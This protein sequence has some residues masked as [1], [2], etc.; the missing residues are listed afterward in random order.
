L[1]DPPLK[2]RASTAGF[3]PPRDIFSNDEQARLPPRTTR[4]WS[5]HP[6]RHVRDYLA[7]RCPHACRR[8]ETSL[9]AASPLDGCWRECSSHRD[10]RPR[11]PNHA[12]REHC[13]GV[14]YLLNVAKIRWADSADDKTSR[15][16]GR[17]HARTGKAPQPERQ[18]DKNFGIETELYSGTPRF[19]LQVAV[20]RRTSS[21]AREIK[22][23]ARYQVCS[24]TLCLPAR[25]DTVSAT[26]RIATR[27]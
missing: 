21:G 13:G 7:Q 8:G 5:R 24:E 11:C 12:R 22:I 18:F 4:R 19:T 25:T 17:K 10:R 27:T 3:A 23:G 15:R 2:L 1:V 9:A 6:F 14:A 20:P 26:L 16:P